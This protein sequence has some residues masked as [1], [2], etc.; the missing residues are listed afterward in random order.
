MRFRVLG[1]LEVQASDTDP[2]A[3]TP[4]A[5]KIRVVLATLLVRANEIVSAESLIDELWGEHPPRTAKTTLQVYISQLRKSLFGRDGSAG[6]LE[7]R[8]PGYVLRMDTGE[9][10]MA[11]F[12]ELHARGREAME[13]RDWATA[14]E[15]QREALELWRGPLLSD[16]PHG[17][18]LDAAATRLAELRTTALEQ[19]VRAELNQGRHHD[20][21]SELQ[22]LAGEFA[23]REEFHAHLMVALY[24]TGRQA[25]ALRAFTR[26][27]RTLVEELAIE[28]G[29]PLQELHARI[30][31][32]DAGLLVPEPAAVP[33]QRVREVLRATARAQPAEPPVDDLPPVDALFTGR[34]TELDRLC[35]LLVSDPVGGCVT[36][37]GTAG[38]GKT[39][40]AVAAAHRSGGEFPGGRVFVELDGED[41]A[42]GAVGVVGA[43]GAG[44][45]VGEVGMQGQ[46]GSTS[47]AGSDGAAGTH[48]RAC[49][50]AGA[51]VGAAQVLERVLRR[52]GATGELP[53]RIADRQSLLRRLTAGR[54]MLFVVDGAASAAQV[55]PLL[56][57]TSGSVVLV[58]CRR[59]PVGIEGPLVRLAALHPSEARE[60]FVAA[61]G[62]RGARETTEPDLP[63]AVETVEEIVRMCGALPG[64][65]RSAA[66]LLAL[67]PHWTARRLAE[68]LRDE[69]VRLDL[70]RRG[71][72]GLASALSSGYAETEDR[73]GFRLLG[74]L[75][76]GPFGVRAAASVFGQSP[77]VAEYRLEAMV[78]AGLLTAEP[79]TGADGLT[80]QLPE[81]LRLFAAER[82]RV[83]EDPAEVRR[84]T[85]RLVA[86]LV[87]ELRQEDTSRALG[88]RSRFPTGGAG[89]VRILEQAHAAGLWPD[90]VRLA[91]ALTPAFEE[92]ADWAAWERCHR[93]A[94]DA[95]RQ[96]GDSPAE[97]RLLRSLG[98]LAWQ[99]RQQAVAADHYGRA[100]QAA[101]SAGDGQEHARTLAGLAELRLDAGALEEAAQLLGPALD[102]T[103]REGRGRYE[104]HRVMALLALEAQGP[105][106]AERHFSVCLR[107]A[108]ALDEPRLESYARRWLNAVRDGGR[109][110]GIELRPG[111]WRLHTAV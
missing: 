49:G 6:A 1:P 22:G 27:R 100:R 10:D 36:V 104:A 109:L 5:A 73:A 53:E 87:A 19:R 21:V 69:N 25:E 14:A 44:R 97:A 71:S 16:T 39:A 8:V 28:P 80:F 55:L 93:L 24:R 59:V 40:L 37:T 82:L 48:V 84:A 31:S 70:L 62:V 77:E 61:A 94:L 83:E 38:S 56:Q 18:L 34:S 9:L 72:S 41:G 29:R 32:G 91:D 35:A 45:T 15:R 111:V 102:T 65:V 7:T 99:R 90:T 74:L 86:A 52:C 92:R 110:P 75:P 42:V 103:G 20:L 57:G 51:P 13:R 23:L 47:A 81:L 63:P 43:V 108:R 11:R 105:A 88:G 50:D 89:L 95:A 68:R 26:L 107:L 4:R 98:D 3:V 67:H 64:A 96:A 66:G 76:P 2:R 79:G 106:A 33:A 12:E 54:R 78:A 60:L 101:R 46:A 58:T 85:A 17:A 30:L